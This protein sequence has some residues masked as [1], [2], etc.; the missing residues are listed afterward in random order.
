[1]KER[2]KMIT[3]MKSQSNCLRIISHLMRLFKK[4]E[5]LTK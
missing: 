4:K 1:M 3:M 5:F 2:K